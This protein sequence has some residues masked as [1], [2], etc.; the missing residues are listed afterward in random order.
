MAQFDVH[1]NPGRLKGVIP[2]VVVIQSAVFDNSDRRVVAPLILAKEFGRV[3][4]KRFN[5]KFTI[6]GTEVVLQ[7]L[8]VVSV[9]RGLLGRPVENMKSDGQLIIDALDEL[10]SQAYG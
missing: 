10:Y 3:E 6:N 1:P 4:S 2:F 9:P 7:P 5:P 8:E